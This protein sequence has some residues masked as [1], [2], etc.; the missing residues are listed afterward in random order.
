[1]LPKS[2]W[3]FWRSVVVVIGDFILGRNIQARS[4][5]HRLWAAL[6]QPNQFETVAKGAWASA[7]PT[8]SAW[9]AAALAL[10]GVD[11]TD[12]A[13]YFY[14][15]SLPHAAWMNTLTGC[16]PIGAMDFC[17]AAPAAP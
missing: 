12:G 10:R 17:R 16:E 4:F 8:P 5:P 15:P 11:P 7:R 2:G 6:H 14:N 9:H 1:V 3:P 13:L